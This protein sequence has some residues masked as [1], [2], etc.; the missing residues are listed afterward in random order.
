VNVLG[1]SVYTSA[2]RLIKKAAQVINPNP[3]QQSVFWGE[4]P[5]SI[6]NGSFGIKPTGTW[7]WWNLPASRHN[8][9]C[10]MSF[11]DGHVEYWKW[12]DTSV[13]AQGYPD[14]G[15]GHAMNVPAPTTDRDL[16]RV[17]ATTP[18]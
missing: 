10:T 16:P 12:R 4:D 3:T 11:F 18:P 5:R 6:D 17:Q 15:V 2:D 13:L 9:G 1:D 14:P 8:K 7:L